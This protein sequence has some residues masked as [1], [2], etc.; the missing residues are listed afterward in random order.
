MIDGD[1]C[2]NKYVFLSYF[3]TGLFSIE[4]SPLLLSGLDKRKYVEAK[5]G[6]TKIW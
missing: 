2:Q 1:F 4:Y 5:S 6:L 3:K